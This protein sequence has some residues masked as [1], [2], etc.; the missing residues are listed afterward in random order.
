MEEIMRREVWEGKVAVSFVL[1]ENEVDHSLG[2]ELPEPVYML[3]P[4]ISYFPLA[5]DKLNRQFQHAISGSED[6]QLWLEYQG[7]PLKWHYPVGVHY[8]LVSSGSLQLWTIT[9]HY[10]NFPSDQLMYCQ[11]KEIVEAHF[12]SRIKEADCL[13]HR[14]EII[15]VLKPQEFEQ[16]WTAYLTENYDNFWAINNKLMAN[17]RGDLDPFKHIP[18]VIYEVDEF[19]VQRLMSAVQTEGGPEVT[20]REL[21]QQYCPLTLSNGRVIIHGVQP[22]LDTS[23]QWLSRHF[24]YPDNFLHVVVLTS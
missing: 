15:Q 6:D 19:P 3:L 18:F 10:K 17:A 24:S 4:R 12:K 11:K 1:D 22:S 13:K 2:R 5:Y 20:L 8:D 14:K 16:L 21:I 7:K 9:V 23:L